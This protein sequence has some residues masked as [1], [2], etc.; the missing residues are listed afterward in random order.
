MTTLQVLMPMGGLGTRFRKVGISTPKPLIEVDGAPMFQRALRSFAPWTGDKRVVVVVRADDDAEH[1]LARQVL[2]AEPGADIVL[3]D[4][5]TRGA[6]E[7]CLEARDRLDPDLPL[8]IMDCDIA[9][10]SPEYFRVLDEAVRSR[11]VDGL[12]LSFASTEPRYSFA[13]V[14]PDGIV[15]RTAEK[16]AISSDALMGV[17]SFTSARVFLEAADRLMARQIDA[18]MPEYYVSL[19]F[20]ELIS[21]GRRV[22]LVRGDFYCF[23][24][25]EELAAYQATG[26]PI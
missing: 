15:V 5:D 26:R 23:G 9:F 12:L 6:V 16:Q 4:H 11:D 14:G 24:T 21:S 1:G 22:G 18:A 19:V 3:L 8:V 25:P 2:E 13:E 7:T 17:Y 20:N 10:D